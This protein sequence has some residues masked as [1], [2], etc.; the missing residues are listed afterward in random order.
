MQS[1]KFF[2]PS[3]LSASRL[4]A[5]LI[6]PFC[7][8][9]GWPWLIAVAATSDALDGWLARKWH[10]VTWQGG[11][12]DAVA[13]KLFVLTALIIFVNAG[14]IDPWWVPAV[15]SRDLLVLMTALFIACRR[16]WTSFKEMPARVSGKLATAGQFVLFLT[17]AIAPGQTF[18][19][20]LFSS[21]CS[22]V[23]A[24]DYGR[25]FGKA[26]NARHSFTE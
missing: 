19:A 10:A 6:F 25:L 5:A 4:V 26:L 18:P 13:D 3:A 23:A 11:L 9:N 8:E 16:V 15:I 20:L 17:V 1:V 14:K 7:P 24:I 22:A 2:I 12:I 21:L